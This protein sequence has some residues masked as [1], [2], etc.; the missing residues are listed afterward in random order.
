M[1]EFGK[2]KAYYAEQ[3]GKEAPSRDAIAAL[4]NQLDEVKT[5]KHR[6]MRKLAELQQALKE[7]QVT[8]ITSKL[9]LRPCTFSPVLSY[10]IH[11][12]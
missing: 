11:A 4:E 8:T 1:L 7:G 12:K 3:N 9:G 5:E 10:A 2:I 6:S